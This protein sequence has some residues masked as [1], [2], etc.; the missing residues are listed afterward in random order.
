[1][2]GGEK[3]QSEETQAWLDSG[4]ERISLTNP[5]RVG[6]SSRCSHVIANSKVSREHTL[7]HYN[8]VDDC[9][10]LMDLGSKNGTYHNGIKILKPMTLRNG[11]Q[12]RI[13]DEVFYFHDGRESSAGHRSATTMGETVLAIDTAECWILLADIQGSTQLSQ[14]LPPEV[15]SEKIRTWAGECEKLIHRH[16]GVLNEYMGDGILAF[17]AAQTT[18]ANIP[19]QVVQSLREF[20]E[21]KS[22]SGLNFRVIVH[23]GEL[24]FGGGV[25]SGREKLSGR[26]LNFLFK[27]EKPAA[28]TGS[29]ICL[30]E[31]AAHRLAPM[32]ALREAGE[33][34]LLGFQGTHRVF[35]PEF[36]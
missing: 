14:K 7:L 35:V 9:W 26:E 10:M 23:F 36:E 17:W 13:G 22:A 20:Q 8:P 12:I 5:F 32:L 30:S 15:L 24:Q 11:D 31:A 2:D 19:E 6:R 1:M 34:E 16:Q 3:S 33:F 25:S 4:G 21:M 28:R 29:K 18:P 27:I